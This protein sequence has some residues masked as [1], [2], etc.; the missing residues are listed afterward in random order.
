[1]SESKPETPEREWRFFLDDMITCAEK[2][3]AYIGELDQA[4]FEADGIIVN[5]HESRT[6]AATRDHLLPKF[7]S[8]EV[9][10]PEAVKLAGEAA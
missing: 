8:G 1:M 2:V 5:I 10:V 9:R 4:G 3:I 7:M 6:L